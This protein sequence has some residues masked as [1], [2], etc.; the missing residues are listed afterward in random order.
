MVDDLHPHI[1]YYHGKNGHIID[2]SHYVHAHAHDDDEYHVHGWMLAM[3]NFMLGADIPTDHVFRGIPP[4]E[5]A[6]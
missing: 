3:E 1:F 5:R 4:S 2:Q 6:S